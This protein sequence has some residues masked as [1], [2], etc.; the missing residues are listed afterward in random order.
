MYRLTLI[1]LSIALAV[2]FVTPPL[3]SSASAQSDWNV[4]RDPFDRAVVARYKRLLARNPADT[5]ALR[6]L[7]QLYRRHRSVALLI[8]EYERELA[9][10]AND[11]AAAVVLGHLHLEQGDRASARRYYEQAA[12]AKPDSGAVQQ[13]L[14]D[15]YRQD[16]EVA[17][18]RSAYERALKVT[19]AKSAKAS[20]ELALAELALSA[21]DLAAARGHYERYFPLAPKDI[22]ARL[23]LGDAL[24]QGGEH[25]AAIAVLEQA[26]DKLR[27][28]PARQIEVVARIGAVHEQAGQED[29]AVQLYRKAIA[30][31][32]RSYYLR[33]ELTARI[34]EIYRRRQSLDELIKEYEQRWPKARRGHFESDTLA[35]LYEETGD[36][37][38]AIDAYRAATKKSP[39]EL[40]TQRRLIALL[41]NA[42][43][44]EEALAQYEVVIRVAPGEPRFQLD[45]AAR[46]WSRGKQREALSL[47]AKVARRFPSDGGVHAAVA[48]LY[49][50]WG[51]ADLALESYARLT[52]IEPGEI[53][54][55]VNLGEQYFLRDDKKRAVAVWKRIIAN[56]SPASYARLGEVYAEHDMLSDALEMYAKAIQLQPEQASHYKGRASV[57]ERRRDFSSSVTD[58]ERVLELTPTT[59]ASKPA[60]R[61]ARRRIVSLLRRGSSGQLRARRRRWVRAFDRT[62][63]D[64]E[65]GYFLV[66]YHLREHKYED[67]RRVLERILNVDAD[68]AEAMEQLVKVYERVH[69]YEAAVAL[70]ERLAELTPA[71]QRDYYTRIAELKTADRKDDEALEYARKALEQSPNDPL[72][73]QRLAERYT[74]MQRFDDAIAAYEKT[75]SLDPQNFSAYF[76]LA[77]L[78]KSSHALDKAAALYRDILRR[79]SDEQLLRRAGREAI[80][81]EEMMGTLGTL[82]RVLTPLTFTFGHKPIYRRVLVELYDRHVPALVRAW[83]KGTPDQRRAAREELDRLGNHGL[84]PLLEAL[85]DDADVRQQ[86]IAVSVLGYLGNQGAAAPLVRVARRPGLSAQSATR[87]MLAPTLESEVRQDALIAAGRLGDPR[88]INDLIAES[89]R[90]RGYREAALFGLGRTGDA[91]AATALI[92][93][94]DSEPR[95]EAVLACLGLAQYGAE[96]REGAGAGRDRRVMSRAFAGMRAL[97][98]DLQRDE[99]ARAACVFGLGYWDSAE[100]SATLAEV[101]GQGNGE[102]QRLAAW[103]LGYRGDRDA[104]GDLLRAYLARSEA[105]RGA[106]HWALWALE[107]GPERA[108]RDAADIELSHFPIGMNGR[109][110]ARSAVALLPGELRAPALTAAHLGRLLTSHEADLVQGL[111]AVFGR[112]RDLLVLALRDLDS[113]DSHLSLGALTAGLRDGAGG[114]PAAR[115]R[116]LAALARVGRSLLPELTGLAKHRDP[117]VRELALSVLSKI[118]DPAVAQSLLAG[119]GD[120][121]PVVRRAAMAAA[122]RHARLYGHRGAALASAVASQLRRDDWEGRSD[123][124]RALAAFGRHADLAALTAAVTDPSA[125]VRENAVRSLGALA[126]AGV[127]REPA[128]TALGR[129]SE[130]DLPII[131]LVTAEQL[132]RIGGPKAREHLLRLAR[133]PDARVARVA[134]AAAQ[135]IPK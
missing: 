127:G 10:D 50:R 121:S 72:A 104:E 41:E 83:R 115:K 51:K 26:A 18:A 61:E 40:D 89:E 96:A 15:L 56:K 101:L 68:D 46:Y 113:G 119:V 82:E 103:A 117:T 9:R 29:Q 87:R 95:G 64:I 32:G 90:D 44:E 6:R 123:A 97:V 69:E 2:V 7:T 110:D 129:A 94:L 14:G 75:V 78:Y 23:Q 3:V 77:H 4:K 60:R 131:R 133:D 84:K 99:Y 55:L 79:G 88:I 109:Y 54:H 126:A 67:A 116:A 112:H 38:R 80:D 52:R 22:D 66:E 71:R 120:E 39:Y 37:E 42:G 81:L 53:S 130:D 62:P 132:G 118:D 28:D 65:A 20:L 63:P 27:T 85:N 76:A 128:V 74:D 59:A 134:K 105:I 111:R 70:L 107:Q 43:R 135:K 125:Y 30:R 58:W 106:I 98:R 8:R 1:S 57:Y 16:G 33:K 47:L 102:A 124:A 100:A 73:H 108:R 21:G 25:Q 35:R 86:R 24:A 48:D 11:Y 92:G 12:E 5:G 34:I 91:R 36:Q 31:V 19:K 93:A 122:A 49:T 17:A 13:A 114:A 45:L